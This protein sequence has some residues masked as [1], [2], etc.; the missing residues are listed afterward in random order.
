MPPYPETPAQAGARYASELDWIMQ[1][2]G[3]MLQGNVLVVTHGEVG[4]LKG[5]AC[6]FNG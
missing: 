2:G 5:H 4:C 6:F 3:G 1:G